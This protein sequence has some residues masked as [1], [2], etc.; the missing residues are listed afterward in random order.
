[1]VAVGIFGRKDV[2]SEGFSFNANDGL[3]Y[4]EH[5]LYLMG[6]QSL[7]A[8]TFAAWASLSTFIILRFIDV[9]F[10]IRAGRYL[11][12]YLKIE[13]YRSQYHILS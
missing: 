5:S 13:Y 12:I 10:P 8:V 7:A 6:V 4:G 9:I 2:I 3:L 11:T 1:M